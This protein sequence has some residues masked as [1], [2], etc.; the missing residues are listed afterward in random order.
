MECQANIYHACAIEAIEDARARIDVVACMIRDN[1]AAK[2]AMQKVSKK[3][4]ILT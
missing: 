4:M 3:S 2:E 1:Q